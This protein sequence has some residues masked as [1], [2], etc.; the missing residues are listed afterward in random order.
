M[1]CFDVFLTDDACFF[2]KIQKAKR[3][4]KKALVLPPR[5]KR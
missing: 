4:R 1:R 3:M 5:E 2:Y